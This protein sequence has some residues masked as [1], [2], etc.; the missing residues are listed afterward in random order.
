MA[1]TG[2][3]DATWP[4]W[5][6]RTWVLLAAGIFA[7][8]LTILACPPREISRGQQPGPHDMIQAQAIKERILEASDVTAVRMATAAIVGTDPRGAMRHVDALF[9]QFGFA[10]PDAA[11]A[12]GSPVYVPLQPQGNIR[13]RLYETYD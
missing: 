13:I 4:P 3:N 6:A 2:G 8:G 1:G 11:P 10:L 9:Q 7:S 5:R 12:F